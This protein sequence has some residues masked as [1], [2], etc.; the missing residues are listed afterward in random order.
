MPCHTHANVGAHSCAPLPKVSDPP[1]DGLN[2]NPLACTRV[3]VEP[4]EEEVYS[5]IG[6]HRGY[7]AHDQERGGGLAAP[8]GHGARVAIARIDEPGYQGGGLLGVPSPVASPGDIGPERTN[9]DHK[10]DEGE[11]YQ[12]SPVAHGVQEIGGRQDG[13]PVLPA[14]LDQVHHG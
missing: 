11:G 2:D 9:N 1:P 14:L 13:H 7:E 8:P 5:E 6:E 10:E 3:A 12:H 4:A